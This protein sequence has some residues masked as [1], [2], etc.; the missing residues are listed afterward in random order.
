MPIERSPVLDAHAIAADVLAQIDMRSPELT[1][2][3]QARL[4][5]LTPERWAIEWHIPTWLREGLDLHS[6]LVDALTRS[7]VL[8]LLAVRLEDDL[9]D[10][11]VI[12]AEVADARQLAR[13]ALDLAL[14]GYRQ[15]FDAGSAIW[16]FIDRS[17]A[18]QRA[19]GSGADL[20]L[21]GA[22]V[23][24]AGFAACLQADRLDLWPALEQSLDGAVIALVLYDQFF[25]WEADLHAGRWNAF[26]AAVVGAEQE[27]A[28]RGRNRARVLTSM[29]TGPVVTEHFR[30]AVRAATDAVAVAAGVGVVG[31]AEFLTSWAGQASEQAAE[32]AAHYHEAAERATRLLLGTSIGGAP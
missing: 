16:P 30:A 32:I 24:I 26:V 8:G 23:K 3:A 27:P 19:G 4:E 15:W 2:L 11:D 7:N 31:L 13:V 28:R 17:M 5:R 18:E 9:E 22:P 14:A 12:A 20:A 29:L 21:R 1:G 10:G 6:G 25:D